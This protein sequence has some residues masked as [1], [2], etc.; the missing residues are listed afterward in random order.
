MG[1]TFRPRDLFLP[2]LIYDAVNSTRRSPPPP[3]PPAE[4]RTVSVQIKPIVDYV[5]RT[6]ISSRSEISQSVTQIN[7]VKI[8][9]AGKGKIIINGNV[10][11][12]Q[13]IDAR[14]TA[15]SYINQ[16]IVNRLAADLPPLVA[17]VQV[18]GPRTDQD[19]DLW[20]SINANIRESLTIDNYAKIVQD[21]F[22]INKSK[23]Y[24]RGR[25]E[26]DEL[27]VQQD[28]ITRVIA[29]NIIN[30]VLNNAGIQESDG[31]IATPPPTEDNT[32][33]AV[34]FVISQCVSS[35]ICVLLLI[36]ILNRKKS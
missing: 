20:M 16:T 24:V 5:Q 33:F 1:F 3:P 2:V 12:D 22:D 30:A 18:S 27:T 8:E 34:I 10:N 15:E 17:N 25:L 31:S 23:I 14:V 26:V 36:L 32:L 19:P 29:I 6:L 21:T 35:I 13:S 11:V 9:A 7:T 28:I 4:T